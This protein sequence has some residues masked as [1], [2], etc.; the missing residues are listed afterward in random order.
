[1]V[2]F[3]DEALFSGKAYIPEC[4]CRPTTIS[5]HM[6][7]QLFK[8]TVTYMAACFAVVISMQKQLLAHNLMQHNPMTQTFKC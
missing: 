5:Y 7:Q 1:M 6:S 2:E 8:K 4:S 3:S